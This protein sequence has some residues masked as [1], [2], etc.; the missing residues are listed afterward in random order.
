M[1]AS[2]R[3]AC[4]SISSAS[5]GDAEAIQSMSRPLEKNLPSP[6]MTSAPDPS[7]VSKS[8]SA[9]SM[10]ASD[11]GL[12]RFSPAASRTIVTSPACSADTIALTAGSTFH[13]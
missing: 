12:N 6:L 13:N 1:R 3:C 9:A 7:V 11:A 4:R 10:A 2:S 5:P 8:S